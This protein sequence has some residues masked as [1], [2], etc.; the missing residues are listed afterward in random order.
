MNPPDNQNGT[1][2][3]TV[4]VTDG[5][6]SVSQQFTAT[7]TAVNDAPTI[8]STAGTSATEDAAYSYTITASDVDGD[9][10]TYSAPTTPG[11]LSFATDTHIL[12]GTPTND[13]VGD[14]S[15]VLR[16]TDGTENVDQS[17]TVTVSNTNDTPVLVSIT[18]PSSVLEDGDNI[19]VAVSPTDIDAGASLTVTVTT[20]N[21]SLFPSGTITVSPESGGTGVELSLIHI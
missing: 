11:W 2:L 7:V 15:V 5:S 8:T 6:E 17:F 12:S 14:H 16:V 20:N 19:V 18:D 9:A 4:S 13:N 1:A 10:L 21:G 3:V